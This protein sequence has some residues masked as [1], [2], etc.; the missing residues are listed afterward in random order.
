VN[1]EDLHDNAAL[2]TVAKTV[3]PVVNHD[4]NIAP[5]EGHLPDVSKSRRKAPR[6]QVRKVVRKNVQ[7]KVPQE[8]TNVTLPVVK[9]ET[10]SKESFQEPECQ[11]PERQVENV[12]QDPKNTTTC[13]DLTSPRNE[14]I[15]ILPTVRD[16]GVD[17]TNVAGETTV[18]HWF[19]IKFCRK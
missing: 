17:A 10:T 12:V 16:S 18:C 3:L 8:E 14:N 1:N 4:E 11:C 2:P 19:Y 7:S 13:R 9:C 15:S 5:E 6:S